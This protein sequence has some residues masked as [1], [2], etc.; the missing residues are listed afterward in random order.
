MDWMQTFYCEKLDAI[1]DQQISPL[2]LTL[3]LVW[4]HFRQK[5]FTCGPSRA[6]RKFD[7]FC[8]INQEGYKSQPPSP[9]KIL[10]SQIGLIRHFSLT[11]K[12]CQEAKEKNINVIENVGIALTPVSSSRYYYLPNQIQKFVA[13]SIRPKHTSLTLFIN[14]F[15]ECPL[16]PSH[17]MVSG[18]KFLK[19]N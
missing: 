9:Q 2:L 12:L 10:S 11:Y 5:N 19:V 15:Q 1:L 8:K 6:Q 13:G 4:N 18:K 7:F 16:H 17:S 14:L 3:I